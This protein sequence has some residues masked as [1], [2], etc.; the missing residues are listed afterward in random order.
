MTAQAFLEFS[1][2]KSETDKES[3]AITRGSTLGAAVARDHTLIATTG[4]QFHHRVFITEKPSRLTI[5]LPAA[6]W[7]GTHFEISDRSQMLVSVTNLGA[8]ISAVLCSTVAGQAAYPLQLLLQDDKNP[9]LALSGVVETKYPNWPS[10]SSTLGIRDVRVIDQKGDPH[11]V[12][13][14]NDPAKDKRMKG[15]QNI[16]LK[17]YNGAW[18]R[19]Q[20]LVSPFAPNLT[21]SICKVPYGHDASG[22]SLCTE[23][24]GKKVSLSH[25]AMEKLFAAA[26]AVEFGPRS[27]ENEAVYAEFLDHTKL[28]MEAEKYAENV[29]S[30]LSITAAMLIPYR[31]DG[32]TVLLPFG[33]QT[34]PSESWS[35]E[36][37]AAPLASDDCDG[38]AAHITSYVHEVRRL[39]A[40][41]EAQIAAAAG[42]SEHPYLY[43]MHRSLSHYEVSV[44]VLGANAANADAANGG[45]TKLAGHAMV[46]FVP[47]LHLV[48]ALHK[49]AQTRATVMNTKKAPSTTPTPTALG[50][51][52]HAH[53]GAYEIS[54]SSP[55][56]EIEA[57]ALEH[58]EALFK[59]D[60]EIPHK[61]EELQII[62]G[63]KE[64]MAQR[65]TIF[66]NLQ[67]LAGEGTSA[68]SA[69]LYT[70][71]PAER[72]ERATRVKFET[73]VSDLLSPSV[74]AVFKTLDAGTDGNHRFYAQFVELI[75]D[76]SS[77]LMTSASLQGR[78]KAHCQHVLV[79]VDS[80]NLILQ[81]GVSPQQLVT[82]QFGAVPL[83]TVNKQEYDLL[84]E[85][86]DEVQQ[87]TLG[88]IAVPMQLQAEE[89]EML[90]KAKCI[91]EEVHAHLS[92]VPKLPE[93]ETVTVDIVI[94]YAALVYN[95]KSV[96]GI[97]N[98]IMETLPPQTAGI[99]TWTPIPELTVDA[100]GKDA[101]AAAAI[102]LYV[103]KAAI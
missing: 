24:V 101:G 67:T 87:N 98:L 51:E 11:K 40:P 90:N 72:A 37:T 34:F 103:N 95:H 102:K 54:M 70:K 56:D 30:A 23:V 28:G 44:A 81:A 89:T 25:N 96:A 84:E 75:F 5:P 62:K 26:I 42:K 65:G 49:G 14:T 20:L 2:S 32:R 94:P 46:L 9:S 93:Q 12:H 58:I 19:R 68:A 82:G 10:I 33:L 60:G 6:A 57:I 79:S 71:N 35:A 100:N 22:Y 17:I 48:H 15:V 4:D 99:A 41:K 8:S 50:S 78:N 73:Q 38:S 83:Y 3:V 92:G 45:A 31:A 66:Q 74:A 21:K 86:F 52:Q 80:N 64:V 69:R 76:V 61:P 63:G 7:N 18:Q 85:S 97:R 55:G 36:A 47:R 29:V 59:N 88:R 13:F 39:F 16:L 43:A 1:V 91:I 53:T 77:P 27:E